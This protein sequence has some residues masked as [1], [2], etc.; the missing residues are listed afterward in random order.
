MGGFGALLD[1]N[2]GGVGEDEGDSADDGV[3][4][5]DSEERCLVGGKVSGIELGGEIRI[6]HSCAA[7]R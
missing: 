2:T 5:H 6:E 7:K 3:W 1:A 4:T